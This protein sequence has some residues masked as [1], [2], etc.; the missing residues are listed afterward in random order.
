MTESLKE[1]EISICRDC[2]DILNKSEDVEQGFVE[3]SNLLELKG[4]IILA[5][6]EIIGNRWKY[7][8]GSD[9]F[10]TPF[11]K[12]SSGEYGVMIQDWGIFVEE[13]KVIINTI[14]NNIT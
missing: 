11:Y 8:C 9:D 2:I 4:G 6:C 14:L 12:Y 7:I 5:F 1:K 3:L 10:A 13:R